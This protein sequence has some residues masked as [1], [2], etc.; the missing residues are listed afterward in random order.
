[1]LNENFLLEYTRLKKYLH[2]VDEIEHFN[3]FQIL[4]IYEDKK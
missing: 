2:L 3:T 1:M 4:R